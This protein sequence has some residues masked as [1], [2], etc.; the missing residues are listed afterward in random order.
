MIATE[1]EEILGVFNL[2]SQQQANGLQTLLATVY[3]ISQ[4]QIVGLWGE[5]PILK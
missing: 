1:Q 4:K 3:V 5:T 2:V